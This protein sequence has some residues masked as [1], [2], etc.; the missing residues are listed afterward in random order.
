MSVF[1]EKEIMKPTPESIDYACSVEQYKSRFKVADA[2]LHI[3][4]VI[5]AVVVLLDLFVWRM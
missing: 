1:Y 4:L 2:A 3:V 5:A